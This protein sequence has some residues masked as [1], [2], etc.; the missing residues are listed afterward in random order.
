[1]DG[2]FINAQLYTVWS[3][4]IEI[5]IVLC[6]K[7][8]GEGLT[9]GEIIWGRTDFRG[10]SHTYSSTEKLTCRT[11][12]YSK[13][14]TNTHSPT[15]LPQINFLHLSHSPR[16]HKSKASW[17]IFAKPALSAIASRMI[18]PHQSPFDSPILYLWSPGP[19]ID[20]KFVF[21]MFFSPRIKRRV[22][23]K[24]VAAF[25][26]S[27]RWYCFEMRL[28]RWSNRFPR[29]S[30][31]IKIDICN[32]VSIP[33]DGHGRVSRWLPDKLMCSIYTYFVP[34]NPSVTCEPFIHAYW[35][36]FQ[37]L[38]EVSTQHPLPIHTKINSE[39]RYYGWW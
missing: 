20:W 7:S 22:S 36:R 6:G 30:I 12:L 11:L 17:N 9:F 38:S 34:N 39:V 27:H 8:S 29:S 10:T 2:S 33:T 5:V 32:H 14:P 4:C 3:N 28:L 37:K 31:L 16:D 26:S 19:I 13:S 1:M 21:D 23:P 25:F 18:A 35:S 24:M 15:Q